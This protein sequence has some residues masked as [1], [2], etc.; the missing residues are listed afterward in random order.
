M[1]EAP[2]RH[3]YTKE[4]EFK[5]PAFPE[6][7]LDLRAVFGFPLEPGEEALVV[8]DKRP[9]PYEQQADG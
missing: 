8:R 9:P 1:S 7:R 6:L 3:G 2:V 4:D 5:T